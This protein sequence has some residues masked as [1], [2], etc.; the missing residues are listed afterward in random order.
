MCSTHTSQVVIHNPTSLFIIE[1]PRKAC[2][3]ITKNFDIER[4]KLIRFKHS[5]FKNENKN[6]HSFK[7]RALDLRRAKE[8][9]NFEIADGDKIANG[10]F[11]SA[12]QIWRV[13][14]K[15]KYRNYKDLSGRNS[16]LNFWQIWVSAADLVSPAAP[17]NL[18]SAAAR[19]SAAATSQP[20][21][22]HSSHRFTF[23]QQFDWFSILSLIDSPQ[24]FT[25]LYHLVPQ[26]PSF[27]LHI[28][29]AAS[30]LLQ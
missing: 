3:E 8:K 21:T 4:G 10:F 11:Q 28:S 9:V 20:S 26:L 22:I 12:S 18:A 5:R 25:R 7:V 14:N 1:S 23:S 30:I 6:I 19:C 17:L 2:T 24:Y 27:K 16:F 15:F 13:E 29:N